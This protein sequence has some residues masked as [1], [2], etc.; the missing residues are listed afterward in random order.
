[1]KTTSRFL[2]IAIIIVLAILAYSFFSSKGVIKLTS[3]LDNTTVFLDGVTYKTLQNGET[4]NIKIEQGTHT[5]LTA[6]DGYFPWT[7]AVI[8]EKGSDINLTP[9]MLQANPSGE[10]ITGADPEYD[11]IS[12]LVRTSPLP[13]R[14]SR[15]KSTAG[16]VE[17]WAV[18][19]AIYT[20]WIGDTKNIPEYFCTIDPCDPI[21][22][23]FKGA[24]SV[25]NLDF[26][27]D[28]EDVL[29]FAAG[30]GVFAIETDPRGTKN[31]QPIFTGIH[32]RFHKPRTNSLY[33]L[34]GINLAEIAL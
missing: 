5:I 15:L 27:K 26:Y 16:N 28:R 6:K 14:E 7:K 20:S 18:G 34:D 1:M 9:F 11:K 29:V 12:A 24:E 19:N 13:I 31:F 4:V 3:T 10:I 17:I 22:E 33:I 25:E 23:V 8:V 32:P 30:N 2:W 21:L